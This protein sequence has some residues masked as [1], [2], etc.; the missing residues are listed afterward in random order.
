MPQQ[1]LLIFLAADFAFQRAP[2]AAAPAISSSGESQQQSRGGDIKGCCG[3]EGISAAQPGKGRM[4]S[5][6]ANSQTYLA[7]AVTNRGK[8]GC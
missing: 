3:A 2:S 5:H 7:K 4:A 8:Q 1:K 6:H